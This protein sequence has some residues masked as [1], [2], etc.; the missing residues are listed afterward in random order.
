MTKF[1][2]RRQPRALLAL[3]LLCAVLGGCGHAPETDSAP[4]AAVVRKGASIAVPAGS[5]LRQSLQVAS[6]AEQTVARAIPVPAVVEADPAHLVRVVPPVAGRIEQLL[7][8][9][10]DTVKA[11]DALFTMDSADVAA[12]HSDASKAQAGLTLARR[13]LERQKELRAADISAHKDLEQAESDYAQALS[14][15]E[16]SKARLAQLGGSL[17]GGNGRV[18]T[19]RSPLSGHVIELNGGQGG[20]WNDTNA[21]VMV[22]ADLSTVWLTAS[23]QEKDLAAVFAGQAADIELNAYPGQHI[24]GK[25][26]YVGEVLD[27]D[28]RTVKVRVAVDNKDGRLKPG[29]FAQVT[30]SAAP[31]QG[32]VVPASALVQSGTH[33][34]VYVETAAWTFEARTV[35]TG[36]HSGEMVEIVSGLKAGTRIVAKEGVLLN[37]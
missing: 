14:E 23:V 26:G 35:A 27:A 16:R 7:K 33:T 31:H 10:G 22:V 19:L 5:P 29:M 13:N 32:V 28:T 37:D 12:A 11:G 24:A 6:A 9:L 17:A 21:P 30:F 2:P 18:Y 36:V 34:Q 4:P 3:P 15:S 1:D 8:H 20:F 25:I